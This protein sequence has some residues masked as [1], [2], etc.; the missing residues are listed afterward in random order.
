M[1]YVQHENAKI[2]R[3]QFRCARMRKITN[4][5]LLTAVIPTVIV[6][7]A[8]A[9]LLVLLTSGSDKS[10]LYA[11]EKTLRNDFDILAQRETETVITM[12]DGLQKSQ[13]NT[14]FSGDSV[15]ILAAHLIRNLKYG[16]DG[17]F[18]VDDTTGTNL[19]SSVREME[20]T[21]RIDLQD[22][23]GK[24]IVKEFIKTGKNGG[25]F[26]DYRFPKTKNGK[27]LPKRSYL[28]YYEPYGWVIG[29]GNYIDDI[30]AAVAVMKDQQTALMRQTLW[31]I[32]SV[33]ILALIGVF[34]I[35][36][37]MT[38]PVVK[39]TEHAKRLAEGDLSVNITKE[40]KDEI[41]ILAET[42]ALMVLKIKHI[43]E[44]ISM[45]SE[46]TVNAGNEFKIAARSISDGANQ[47][48]ASVQEVVSTIEE[49][50]AN[51]VSNAQNVRE[52]SAITELV[53]YNVNQSSA[54][55][56]QTVQALKNITREISVI[57]DIA[58]QTNLLA[59]NAAIQAAHVSGGGS[60]AG[61]A[62][63]AQQISELA[64]KSA[65]AAKRVTELSISGIKIAD[66]TEE[67]LRK[68]VPEIRRTDELVKDISQAGDEQEL[69]IMQVNNEVSALNTLSQHN[70]AVSEQTE[71]N[72][73]E[74]SER[75]KNM[76]KI[77]S[78]FK[79]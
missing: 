71:S 30:D 12:L 10:S 56:S 9:L 42:L 66:K 74:L 24:Y 26:V 20:G 67:M 60:G 43:V 58:L 5:I 62:I 40:T 77:I 29:T 31:F 36:K 69:G 19:V 70:A 35:S 38:R 3:N 33:V 47:L 76:R 1:Q 53:A 4:K 49:I 78:F 34:F 41:G 27:P 68:L 61:F 13:E 14:T 25:G 44:S 50:S 73:I 6:G 54:A 63:I 22:S 8:T 39:L 7:L 18:W 52:T 37:R 51:I 32:F 28:A 72:A 79:K 64:E 46:M 15:K 16:A 65:Q 75:A 48:A 2:A 45:E 21:N 11:Y 17:Y 23:D 57:D 59:L 55:V